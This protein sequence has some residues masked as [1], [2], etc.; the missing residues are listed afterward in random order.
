M[1]RPEL[2]TV[3]EALAIV[4]DSVTPLDGE[5]VPGDRLDLPRSE[6]EGRVLQV[7][8]RRFARLVA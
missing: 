4:L 1:S 6:L 3:D 2:L 8:K 5:S 7:G